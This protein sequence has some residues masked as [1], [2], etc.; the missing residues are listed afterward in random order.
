MLKIGK[1]SVEK[2]WFLKDLKGLDVSS[3]AHKSVFYRLEVIGKGGPHGTEIGID[4]NIIESSWISKMK[5]N[6]W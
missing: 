5:Y 4:P 3:L 1:P 6:N 2:R